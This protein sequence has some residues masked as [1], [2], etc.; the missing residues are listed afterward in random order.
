MN[1]QIVIYSYDRI[2]LNNKKGESI[3][4][5]N[6]AGVKSMF[7]LIQNSGKLQTNLQLQKADHGLPVNEERVTQKGENFTKGTR[8]F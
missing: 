7:S 4:F 8:T 1:K 3:I 6:C 2:L 5:N